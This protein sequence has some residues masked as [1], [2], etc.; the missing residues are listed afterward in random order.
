MLYTIAKF[1]FRVQLKL[2]RTFSSYRK[3]RRKAWGGGL[4]GLIKPNQEVFF[5]FLGFIFFL[6]QGGLTQFRYAQ[7][8]T[9]LQWRVGV[10]ILPSSVTVATPVGAQMI[11]VLT[12]LATHSIN[13]IDRSR[14]ALT[15]TSMQ[16]CF[17]LLIRLR[18]QKHL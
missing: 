3:V 16:S 2:P 6:F 14:F 4:I 7:P 18:S 11:A 1:E 13:H 15:H 10:V 8:Q 12:Y 9:Q 5:T 17:N